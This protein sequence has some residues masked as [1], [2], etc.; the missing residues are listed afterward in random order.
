[1]TTMR[2]P[3]R[4][5]ALLLALSLAAPVAAHAQWVTTHEQTYLPGRWNWQFL[6]W[7]PSAARLFN[8][9]DYG[10]AILYETLWR[11]PDAPPSRLEQREYDHLVT[12][13]L[14]RPPRLPLEE[15][16]IEVEYAKLAPEA[17]LMFEWAH[18]LHRQIYDVWAD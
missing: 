18:L 13:V 11:H 12:R 7:Y 4:R 16:A 17:K 15:A 10:H 14:A 8:A 9:F 5:V 1:M 6:R 2:F 3:L